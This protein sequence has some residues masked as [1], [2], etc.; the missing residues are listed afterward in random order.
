MD[1]QY[2]T[3]NIEKNRL[4]YEGKV[5][6]SCYLIA[7][8]SFFLSSIGQNFS[9]INEIKTIDDESILHIFFYYNQDNEIITL[10]EKAFDFKDTIK[11]IK[12][13]KNKSKTDLVLLQQWNKFI[14]YHRNEIKKFSI[15]IL[16]ICGVSKYI[17]LFNKEVLWGSH[18]LNSEMTDKNEEDFLIEHIYKSIVKTDLKFFL[19]ISPLIDEF[20]FKELSSDISIVKKNSNFDFYSIS[21]FQLPGNIDLTSEQMKTT[22]AQFF[23]KLSPIWTKI[24]VYDTMLKDISNGTDAESSL[25]S[26]LRTIEPDLKITQKAIDDNIYIQKSINSDCNNTRL[27]FEM[28]I[29]TVETLIKY[30]E[31][32]ET[33][34]PYVASSLK[35]TIK[36]TEDLNSFVIVY[37]LLEIDS[38]EDSESQQL[39]L[40]Q[41]YSK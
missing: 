20:E 10:K 21:L 17:D 11:S 25:I 2:I 29:C 27:S 16:E 28:A 13:I 32:D 40:T 30:F 26:F 35:N 36:K 19:N 22:R 18:V 33:L 38:Q 37:Y 24:D 34:L 31:L 3:R 39:L 14:E 5:L 4:D 9:I 6:K 15:S 23:S 12:K 1:I 8:V 7:D 41:N